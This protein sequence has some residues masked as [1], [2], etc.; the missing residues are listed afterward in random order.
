MKSRIFLDTSYLLALV[1]K[2]D[3][4]H[5]QAVEASKKYNG[6][7]L[8]TALILVELANSLAMPPQRSIACAL[9]EKIQADK[10]TKIV[11]FSGKMFVTA[12]N[13]Y[14]NRPDKDW[15]LVDCFSFAAMA[16]AGCL[17]ALTLDTHFQQAGYIILP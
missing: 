10:R 1:R 17:H 16:G 11:P 7:F 12:F 15:G 8:T 3:A 14:K 13:L 5:S 9:I 2:K 4:F 6:P